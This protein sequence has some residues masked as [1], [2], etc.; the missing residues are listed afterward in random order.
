[1]VTDGPDVSRLTPDDAVVALRSFPRRFRAALAL[2]DTDDPGVLRQPGPD[3]LSA[4][5]HAGLAGNDLALLGE[6]VR[7]VLREQAA[8][9]P[10]AVV[11]PAARPQAAGGPGSA[12][13]AL[14]L[15]ELEA[16]ALAETAERVAP[17]DWSRVATV[18]G[19]RQVTALDVLREAVRATSVHLRG[20]ERTRATGG[21]AG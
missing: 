8:V 12:D 6:A 15:V 7:Q 11:D 4:L 21:R 18:P 2:A 1:V 14:D 5:D 17:A 20:A 9:L 3:G 13:A 10:A 16:E 19:G